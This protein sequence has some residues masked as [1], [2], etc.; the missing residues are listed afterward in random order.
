MCRPSNAFPFQD[1]VL[2]QGGTINL[3]SWVFRFGVRYVF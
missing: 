1:Q 2:V 3:S